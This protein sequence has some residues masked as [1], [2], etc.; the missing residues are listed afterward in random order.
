[1]PGLVPTDTS[2]CS[3]LTPHCTVGNKGGLDQLAD[4]KHF[5]SHFKGFLGVNWTQ[6]LLE[7]CLPPSY[8]R[9]RTLGLLELLPNP[10]RDVVG[11]VCLGSHSA[12]VGV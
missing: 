4:V 1:M 12:V 6:R 8:T 9:G 2:T 7:A 10:P 11:D 5:W 3:P